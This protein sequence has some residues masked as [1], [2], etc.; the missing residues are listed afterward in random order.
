M[1][2]EEGLCWEGRSNSTSVM[3]LFHLLLGLANKHLPF[4]PTDRDSESSSH[5]LIARSI[6]S[7]S[8]RH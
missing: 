7:L 8:H 6:P 3:V 4:K 2:P 1:Q 5:L